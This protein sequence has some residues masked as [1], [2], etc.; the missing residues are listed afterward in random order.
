MAG[1]NT[2]ST[3]EMYKEVYAQGGPAD[4]VPN[5]S[6]VYR[7]IGFESDL[8][9]ESWNQ[10]VAL[11]HEHGFTYN[12]TGG[13]VVTLNNPINAVVKNANTSGYEMVGRARLAYAAASRAASNKQAFK[14]YWDLMLLNL[15][16]GGMKRLELTLLRGQMGLGI[17]Q[18]NSSGT[19]TI[20][21]ASWSPTTWAGM[22]GAVLEAFTTNAATATQHNGDLTVTAVNFA[23]RTVTVTG[24]NS[25]VVQGDYL[26]FKGAKTTT[27]YNEAAGLVKIA[28]NSGSLFGIDAASYN[29]WAGNV[30]TSFG[31]PSMGRVLNAI[32]QPVGKGLEE[33]VTLLTPPKAWEY[34]NADLAAQRMFDG[35]YSKEK[36]ENGAQRISYYGQ[37]GEIE[38]MSHPYLWEGEMVAF[39]TSPYKRVGSAD[40]GMGVPGTPDGSGERTIFFHVENA[41]AVEARTFSD[42]GLFCN[43]PSTSLYIDGV[44]YP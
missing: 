44:T 2:Q 28:Q 27:G 19:L 21:A 38:V 33:K 36:A 43:R 16:L 10:A 4:V 14:K 13:G 42:Q 17:V 3:A 32:V 11:T 30:V 29:L 9:G 1:E 8:L 25:A 20:T 26:F 39:P 24:T 12:G 7:K 41:N 35:S 23:N 6:I 15:K 34:L 22:E 5:S 18:G 31:T 40:I 37:A